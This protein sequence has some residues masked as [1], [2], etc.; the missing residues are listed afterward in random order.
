[1]PSTHATALGFYFTYMWPLLPLAS[2]NLWAD[3]AGVA[4][5]AALTMWSRVILGY[6]TPAQVAAG[7]GVGA[8]TAVAWK[9]LW[10]SNTAIQHGLQT[11]IET[12]I[13]TFL[14]WF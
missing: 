12:A 10:D 2:G 14:S 3:R 6:H 11:L 4:T 1:M 8:A 5:L 7:A 13:S 9:V